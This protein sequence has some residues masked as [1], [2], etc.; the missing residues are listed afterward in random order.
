VSDDDALTAVNFLAQNELVTTPSGAAGLAAILSNA[1]L[2]I[3]IPDNSICLVIATEGSI[4][5]N[6]FSGPKPD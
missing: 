1:K 2:D 5:A 6:E 3:A 4:Y